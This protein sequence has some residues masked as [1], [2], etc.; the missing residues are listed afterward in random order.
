MAWKERGAISLPGWLPGSLAYAPDGKWLAIGGSGG[1][2]QQ[3][4]ALNLAKNWQSETAG[5]FAAVAVSSD[6]SVI[7]ATFKDGVRFLEPQTGKVGDAVTE[8]GCAP[9]AVA[10]FPEPPANGGAP[11][12]HKVIFGNAHGYFV[13]LWARWPNVSTIQ[14]ATRPADKPAADPYAVPLAV[15]PTGER[16]VV[17]GPVDRQTGKNVLWAWSAGSGAGNKLLSGHKATVTAAAWSQDG[18]A[19]VTADADGVVIT[20]DASTF[21]EK[22]RLELGARVAAVA[23]SHDARR[24]AAAATRPESHE[25]AGSYREE[26]YAWDAEHAQAKPEPLYRHVVGQTFQGMAAVTFSPDGR[27]LAAGFCNFKH[28][29]NLGELI[30]AVHVWERVAK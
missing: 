16:A 15:S 21:Q 26:V 11:A 1:H 13:K 30:G 24:I 14:S 17:T 23:I 29:A 5:E 27:F 10:L 28:L 18:K 9:S 3:N 20:W 22:S 8:E 4:N 19:I 6:G 25:G 12:F 7:G 2:V